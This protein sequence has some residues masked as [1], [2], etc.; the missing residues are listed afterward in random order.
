MSAQDYKQLMLLAEASHN[1]VNPSPSQ[2]SNAEQTT[3]DIC[4][5]KCCAWYGSC[6][7]RG[8]LE[9][10]S[11]DC[12]QS[13]LTQRLGK[14]VQ[15][16]KR[17][18]ITAGFSVMRL[19]GWE[20]GTE[21]DELSLLPTPRASKT[22]GYAGEGFSPT[23]EQAVLERLWPT[24]TAEDWKNITLPPSQARRD[25]VSGEV[26]RRGRVENGNNLGP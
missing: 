15:D 3:N 24:P 9:K 20:P 1:L 12:F 10:T 25:T 17:Q 14:S 16:W 23:L 26:I 19:R 21:G 4:G 13:V 6:N 5:M 18:D 22:L 11:M 2:E 8:S 7:H